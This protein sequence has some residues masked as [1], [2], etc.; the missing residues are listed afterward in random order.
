MNGPC[1]GLTNNF[2]AKVRTE[3]IWLNFSFGF[4]KNIFWLRIHL[5]I[6][7]RNIL[8]N[9]R[10]YNF[11]T[12]ILRFFLWQCRKLT[13]IVKKQSA[14]KI[15]G[16][17]YT[18]FVQIV[19]TPISMFVTPILSDTIFYTKCWK[20]KKKIEKKTDVKNQKIGERNWC[21]KMM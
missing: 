15:C 14:R 2:V 7:G 10:V 17:K 6:E 4:A 18:K 16:K 8:V 1:T 11:L 19:L 3:N 12:R 21:K 5:R 20:L 9:F 13:K